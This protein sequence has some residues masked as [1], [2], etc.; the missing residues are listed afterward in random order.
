[1]EERSERY[2]TMRMTRAAKKKWDQVCENKIIQ[3]LT[4]DGL[5]EWIS[6]SNTSDLVEASQLLT[7]WQF[8]SEWIDGVD[9]EIRKRESPVSAPPKPE[10]TTPTPTSTATDIKLPNYYNDPYYRAS[11]RRLAEKDIYYLRDREREFRQP[12]RVP[13]YST[14]SGRSGIHSEEMD[15]VAIGCCVGVSVGAICD[16]Q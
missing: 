12:E 16:I 6:E 8:P 5:S 3:R 9:N 15:A 10:V 7:Y 14:S 4:T 2:N 1:M 13:T 11:H